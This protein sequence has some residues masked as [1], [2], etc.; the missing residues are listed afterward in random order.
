MAESLLSRP[1]QGFQ[2]FRDYEDSKFIYRDQ[3]HA[4]ICH[5]CGNVN[6]P[7]SPNRSYY[8]DWLDETNDLQIVIRW[9]E[10]KGL[11]GLGK[12]GERICYTINKENGELIDLT[13][14]EFKNHT[15]TC[16][17][18]NRLEAIRLRYD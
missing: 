11:T 13:K 10:R 6:A 3:L 8:Q 5:L 1:I 7:Y 12:Y 2:I 16:Q 14:K 4:L 17:S 15:K 18:C 9:G